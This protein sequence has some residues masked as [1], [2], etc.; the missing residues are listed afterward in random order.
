MRHKTLPYMRTMRTA[1]IL[2]FCLATTANAVSILDFGRS[3][4]EV[5]AALLK[6][7]FK[8]SPSENNQAYF[9][10]IRGEETQNV[11]FCNGKLWAYG[12]VIPGGIKAFIRLVDKTTNERGLAGR[13][14]A[15]SLLG[16]GCESIYLVFFGRT[17]RT[18]F[19]VSLL[20]TG[21]LIPRQ[22]NASKYLIQS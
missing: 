21:L 16:S 13:Y 4:E 20:N 3:Q 10:A 7:G 17:S 8:V 11:S 18:P 15:W 6:Q 9:F 12:E 1:M 5:L 19:L 22:A 14:F 2:C